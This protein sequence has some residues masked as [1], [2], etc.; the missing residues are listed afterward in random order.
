MDKLSGRMRAREKIH[1]T[2]RKEIAKYHSTGKY[3][4]NKT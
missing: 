4:R 2:R 3:D 1:L